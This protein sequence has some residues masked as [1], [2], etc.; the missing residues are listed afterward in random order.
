MHALV[1]VPWRRGLEEMGGW[2]NDAEARVRGG[3]GMG[4]R[5]EM[6]RVAFPRTIVTMKEDKAVRRLAL[7]LSDVQG[8]GPCVAGRLFRA[9]AVSMN[10]WHQNDITTSQS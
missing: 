10:L 2:T 1:A 5:I 3:V 6:S 9:A 4:P 8:Q 7:R